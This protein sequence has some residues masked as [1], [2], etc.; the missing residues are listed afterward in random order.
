M[1]SCR[2]PTAITAP[3]WRC[4]TWRSTPIQT[5][6][7]P[8]WIPTTTAAALLVL[9]AGRRHQFRCPGLGRD[10]RDRRSRPRDQRP[11][12]ALQHFADAARNLCHAEH[13]F[14]RYHQ[15]LERHLSAPHPATIWSPAVERR[16]F[17]RLSAT[18]MHSASSRRRPPSDRRHTATGPTS[19]TVTFSDAYSTSGLSASDFEVNGIAATS[20]TTND[21][22]TQITFTFA[23]S[24]S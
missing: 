23:T 7:W 8:S 4:P 15:R 11:R 10:H 3:T 17:R 9:G 16:S 1:P 12:L 24:P 18:W 13:E 5:P 2:W 20:F 14:S 6:A 21:A 22:Q 19:F